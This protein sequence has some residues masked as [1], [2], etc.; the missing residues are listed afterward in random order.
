MLH[1]RVS[2]HSDQ[3]TYVSGLE[4][5][6]PPAEFTTHPLPGPVPDITFVHPAAEAAPV[7]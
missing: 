6:A 1:S 7:G 5:M 4:F 2:I 3:V